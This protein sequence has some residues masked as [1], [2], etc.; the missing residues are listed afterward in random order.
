MSPRARAGFPEHLRGAC[1]VCGYDLTMLP[2]DAPVCPE[3]G[4]AIGTAWQE[5]RP[6]WL[7]IAALAIAGTS[8]MSVG[9]T[10]GFGAVL[11]LPALLIGLWARSR[12][13]RGVDRPVSVPLAN[14]AIMLSGIIL[15]IAGVIFF[16]FLIISLF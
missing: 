10:G 11:A 2:D 9:C 12:G 4:T 7:S 5:G 3:C 1:S 8:L 13:M 14:T 15:A 6:S 16:S